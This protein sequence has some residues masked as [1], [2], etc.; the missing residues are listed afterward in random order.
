MLSSAYYPNPELIYPSP[1]FFTLFIVIDMM[2]MKHSI[3]YGLI[4][5]CMALVLSACSTNDNDY[6]YQRP[7]TRNLPDIPEIASVRV[8]PPAPQ[9]TPPVKPK[10]KPKVQAYKPKV[11]KYNP[12][13]TTN[14]VITQKE[15]A[16][17]SQEK[18]WEE[19]IKQK[20]VVETDPYANIPDDSSG[21]I[22][23]KPKVVN[24]SANSSTKKTAAPVLGTVKPVKP[25]KPQIPL[26]SSSAVKTLLLKA[27]ADL[28][29]GRT[30]SA[31]DKL[32]RGLRIEPRNSL[33]WY[34]LARANYD[35]RKY[36]QTI[37]M[38]KKS[39][40]NTDRDYIIAKNW[41]LIKKAGQKSGDTFAV[42]EAIDYFK[43]NP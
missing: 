38:A 41:M 37:S 1:P 43:I 5:T 15:V 33:L 34:Q 16:A 12:N 17:V 2:I 42:K 4:T 32:E 40:Q 20:S 18:K 14:T 24:S 9:Y 7:Q 39:I 29:I 36:S 13:Q 27:R 26:E 22:K 10:V 23:A 31:I 30:S 11:H 8:A 3:R 28:A 35:K 19:E 25:S 6:I 21:N